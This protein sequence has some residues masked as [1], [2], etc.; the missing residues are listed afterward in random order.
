MHAFPPCQPDLLYHG[1]VLLVT[2]VVLIA[3]VA[4]VWAIATRGTS[5]SLCAYSGSRRSF[6][7]FEES[8]AYST[9]PCFQSCVLSDK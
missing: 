6:S 4:L 3:L 2:L 1:A 9:T 8:M 5:L 7:L